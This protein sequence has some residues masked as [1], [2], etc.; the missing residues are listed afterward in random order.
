VFVD[1]PHHELPSQAE[2]DR[3]VREALRDQGYRVVVI[4]HA[5][6][7]LDQIRGNAE[8]FAPV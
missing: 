1:G 7:I 5:G 4:S 8:L 3:H 6:Q 2:S